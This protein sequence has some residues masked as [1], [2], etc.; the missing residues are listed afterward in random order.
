MFAVLPKVKVGRTEGYQL[1][2]DKPYCKTATVLIT[3]DF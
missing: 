1:Q 3:N 2:F